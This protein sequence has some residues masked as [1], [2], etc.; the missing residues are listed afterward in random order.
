[1]TNCVPKNQS[2]HSTQT[3]NKLSPTPIYPV[4]NTDTST[5]S[6]TNTPLLTLVPESI[7]KTIQPLIEDPFNCKTPCFLSIT[8]GITSMG[9]A[10]TLLSSL[11]LKHREGFDP[12][13]GKYFYSAGYKSVSDSVSSVTLFSTNNIVES[14]EITPV[15]AIPADGSPREWIAYSP[16]TLIKKFGKPSRVNFAL[17][18]GPIVTIGMT[19]YYDKYDL[20]ADYSVLDSSPESHVSPRLCPLVAPFD[21]V[22]IWIGPNPPY[23]PSFHTE[24]LKKATSLTIEQFIELML[25]DPEDACFII[26]ASV[27]E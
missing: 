11:G 26:D 14:I 18:L 27:F 22:R 8:P 5:F 6:P 3:G 10:K 20:I 21:F 9:E 25:G 7:V 13:S 19:I 17:D 24:T 1:M 12:L 4:S 15:I 23:A 2:M 16:E